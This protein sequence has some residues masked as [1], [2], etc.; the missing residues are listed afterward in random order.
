MKVG[1]Q[2][3]WLRNTNWWRNSSYLLLWLSWY[4]GHF[5]HLRSTV[6]IQSSENFIYYQL[7]WKVK[8]Y[9]TVRALLLFFIASL[10]S[11]RQKVG[12]RFKPRTSWSKTTKVPPRRNTI[13]IN[14]FRY[15][16]YLIKLRFCRSLQCN[17]HHFK[18]SM[19]LFFSMTVKRFLI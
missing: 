15:W 19:L 10:S 16:Y 12:G 1:S 5:W 18:I 9:D 3:G 7:H 4:S 11:N 17:F 6:R 14:L 8:H 2:V 13:W